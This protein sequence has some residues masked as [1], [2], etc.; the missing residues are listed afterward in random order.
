MEGWL[1][2]ALL[3]YFDEPPKDIYTL[4]EDKNI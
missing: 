3:K 2:F 4:F 1:C